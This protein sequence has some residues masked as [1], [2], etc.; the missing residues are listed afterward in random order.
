MAKGFAG[1]ASIL[2]V[3]V[4]DAPNPQ[5]SERPFLGIVMILAAT[6]LFAS[7]DAITKTL[8]NEFPVSVIIMVRFWVM[9]VYAM[10]FMRIKGVPLRQSLHSPRPYL[11]VF[12]SLVLIVE[13]GFFVVS[14]RTLS[15]AEI[16]SLMATFPLMVTALSI[17]LLGEKVG[18]RRWGAV[19]VG[20]AG[21]LIILRPGY[22]VFDV[23]AVYGLIT[24]ALFALYNVLTR[25][26]G[27]TDSSETSFFYFAL[28]GVVACTV[29]GGFQWVPPS[30]TDLLMML[31]IGVTS[32]FA[33]LFLILALN[34]AAAAT[35]QPFNYMLLVWAVIVGYVVFGDLPDLWTV[36]G[37]LVIVASGLYTIYR[38]HARKGRR[39]A[40]VT[41][42]A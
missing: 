25:L 20:F 19:A 11:Q 9:I 33:H 14:V 22:G 42:R 12:R 23:G 1:A 38:E 39:N 5:G 28:V 34:Y 35:L 16:H 8:S 31:G 18:L 2:Y 7:Q 6:F 21:V 41:P 10:I 4:M 26:V 37:A 3:P 40:E 13:I 15:L 27:R 24:A 29:V 36:A 32:S 17:P 30:G